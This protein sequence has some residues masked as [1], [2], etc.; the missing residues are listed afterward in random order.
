MKEPIPHRF[1][2]FQ[3]DI[4]FSLLF[5]VVVVIITIE[6]FISNGQ[7]H[8]NTSPANQRENYISINKEEKQ[9]TSIRQEQKNTVFSTLLFGDLIYDRNVYKN[10]PDITSLK[11]HFQ[12]RYDKT[13]PYEEKKVSLKDISEDVD[14]VWL[15][16]E[17]SIGKFWSGDQEKNICLATHKSIAFCSHEDILPVL[18]ELWFTMVNLANNHTMDGWVKAHLKTVE[19][20]EKYKI[21]YFGFV[22]Q[23]SYFEKD[24]VY[25]GNIYGQNFA[26][27]GYDY[28]IRGYLH[29]KYCDS[30]KAYKENWYTNFVVVHRWPEYT[31]N[32][33]AYQEKIAKEL[34]ACGADAIFG[35]HPHVPQDTA[36]Y[37]G[38][39]VF[40]SLGNFLFDQYFDTRT[41]IGAYAI[42]HYNPTNEKTSISTGTIPAWAKI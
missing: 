42:F 5:A 8:I 29:K 26:R 1:F 24:Y 23:G 31:D 38:K 25:T 16:L 6:I 4:L 30:L 17:S 40:Y 12:Y 27:H 20:L 32:H 13:I 14:F 2:V 28:S 11:N 33:S 37:S 21:K 3:K 18:K 36:I 15:N 7:S 35:G 39:V 9:W 41:Q 19:L 22:S 10:L 34:L